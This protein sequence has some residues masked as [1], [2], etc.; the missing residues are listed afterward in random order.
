MSMI[1]SYWTMES[2]RT[3]TAPISMNYALHHPPSSKKL[4]SRHERHGPFE[5]S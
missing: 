1:E 2:V 5:S 4:K 3:T